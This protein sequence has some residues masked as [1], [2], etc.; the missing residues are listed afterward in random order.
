MGRM[1]ARGRYYPTTGNYGRS[2]FFATIVGIVSKTLS[3]LVVDSEATTLTWSTTVPTVSFIYNGGSQTHDLTQ[4]I[5]GFNSS[6]HGIR[7]YT[8]TLPTGI[9][10]STAG[11]LTYNGTSPEATA[12][13][14]YEIYD[15]AET[16]WISRSIAPGVI[17]AISLST[18]AEVSA[19]GN[20]TAYG[21][22]RDATLDTSIKPT[23]QPGSAKL[24]VL[25]SDGPASGSIVFTFPQ[26]FGNGT[27]FWVSYRVRAPATYM[28]Q[29]WPFTGSGGSNKLSITSQTPYP[30]GQG[31]GSNTPWECVIQSERQNGQV[32]GYYQDGISTALW[33]SVGFSS[34]DNS[35]DIRGQPLIDRGA[36]PLTGVN[37]D[38]GSAWT[39]G[40]QTRARYGYMYSAYS[41][42]RA[43]DWYPG[44]G[45]PISGGVR[46]YP[47][48]W[49]TITQRITIGTFGSFNSRRTC[50]VA[51]EGQAYQQIFDSTNIRFGGPGPFD[52]HWLLPYVSDRVSGGRQISS[53][54]NNITGATLLVCG[55][56][57]PIGNGT[58]EYN[59]TTQRFRWNGQGEFQGTARGFSSANGKL[60]L[61]VAAS[62]GDSY[63]VVQVDPALLPTSGTVTDTVTIA[64]GRPDTYI[65]YAEYILSTQ[66]INA[67]G[68]FPPVG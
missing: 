60:T 58:L 1:A 39:T 53:R 40:Q 16:D 66:A 52:G 55:L 17:Q 32:S 61:N 47:D 64:N 5:S 59:A 30:L 41:N 6:L 20:S 26:T 18:T 43:S 4:Y 51:R 19:Y 50:W 29:P 56:S 24:L 54:T 48:E 21:D 37:P 7:V 23:G 28:Y 25:N 11:I 46:Q 65:N 27:T 57:T 3:S 38:T 10:L 35:S 12:S 33:H 62:S 9:T 13:V 31:R 44:F 67:P 45:D 2:T 34:P 36:N 22:V 15:L 14:S 68:G 63:V 8:G 42:P 49:L